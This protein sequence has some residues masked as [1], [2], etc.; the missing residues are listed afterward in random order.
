[1]ANFTTA[2]VEQYSRAIYDCEFNRGTRVRA[3]TSGGT[4]I[5]IFDIGDGAN[6]MTFPRR[7]LVGDALQKTLWDRSAAHK[8]MAAGLQTCVR[9]RNNHIIER[10]PRI[11]SH[12][13]TN[14]RA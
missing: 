6:K 7:Y 13:F 3:C 2:E 9:K 1:M 8:E 10:M 4:Q 11:Q 14:L 5:G 12:C